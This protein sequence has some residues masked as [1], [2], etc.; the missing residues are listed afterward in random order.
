MKNIKKYSWS[1]VL[2][3][4][5]IFGTYYF[6][7][8]DYKIEDFFIAV[9]NCN[10]GFLFCAFLALFG[11]CFFAFQYFRRILKYFGKKISWYQAFG[12]HFTEVYFSA[13]TPSSIGGQPVQMIEMNRDGIPY[14][15]STVLILLNTLIYKIALLTIAVIGFLFCF[16]LL[17]NQSAL[18]VWLVALGF[19]TTI[20]LII[21]FL[22]LVYSK[23]LI[24]KLASIL[25]RLGRKL[26]IKKIDIYE[27]QFEDALKGYQE[28]AK[29]TKE[30]PKILWEAYFILLCQ[31]VCLLSISYFIY[32]SFGLHD[33]S[34]LE[35]LAFQ[36]GITLAS[37]FMPFPGGVVVSEGLLLQINEFIYGSTLA[38]PAMILLRTVSFYSIVIFSGIFYVYFHFK[39]RKK[40]KN[41]IIEGEVL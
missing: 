18:F 17:W 33:L 29:L 21:F 11:Y 40:A 15:I 8:K 2:F 13:I 36:A 14:R 26:K 24:P 6:V 5:L 27:K 31:R 22:M 1:I 41:I 7:L 19:I 28:C 9:Q 25:F 35:M 20:F 38:T 4:V 12:Y 32:L 3:L 37:D 16:T 30:H 23:K 10:K 34:L 39:K